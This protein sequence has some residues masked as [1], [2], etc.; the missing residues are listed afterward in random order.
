MDARLA[1]SDVGSVTVAY[2]RQNGQFRQINE[3]PSY[4]GTDVLQMAGNLR[5][6]RFL[7]APPRA[8]DAADGDLRA[9]RRQPELLTG[10][11][12]RGDALTGLRKP[13]SRSATVQPVDPPEPAGHA[14]GSPRGWWTRCR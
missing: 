7:P 4:R 5:L 10:T 2:V 11:D 12:I 1:A 13:D 14:A 9:D 3:D 8:R 6:D